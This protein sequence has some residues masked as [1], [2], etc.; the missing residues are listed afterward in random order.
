MIKSRTFNVVFVKD[1]QGNGVAPAEKP[2]RVVNYSGDTVT[3]KV[4]Q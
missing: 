1:G 3:V 2:D 4:S